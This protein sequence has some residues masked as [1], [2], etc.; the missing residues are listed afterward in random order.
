MSAR[1]TEPLKSAMTGGIIG[2]LMCALMNHFIVP[3]P[4]T[5]IAN[6]INNGIGGLITG[7]ITGFMGVYM[8]IRKGQKE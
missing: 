4:E 3:F 6:T 8:Y 7:L 5:V 2:F 1:I